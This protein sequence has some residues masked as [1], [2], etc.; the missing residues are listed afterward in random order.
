MAA[1]A[2]PFR[3]PP[4]AEGRVD[5]LVVAGEHSGDEQAARLVRE[6]KARRPSLRILDSDGN[7]IP[8]WSYI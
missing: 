1:P 2:L 8:I 6:L 5:L 3:F 4:P 7:R